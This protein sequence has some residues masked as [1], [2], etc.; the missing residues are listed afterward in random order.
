MF[1]CNRKL[2]HFVIYAFE[3]IKFI[4]VK[5]DDVFIRGMLEKLTSLYNNYF[6]QV[7]QVLLQKN[8]Q[9]MSLKR[10]IEVQHSPNYSNRPEYNCIMCC[11]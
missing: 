6:R 3:D 11:F 7:G 9:I 10:V 1:C 2:C 4:E 5:S 8:K